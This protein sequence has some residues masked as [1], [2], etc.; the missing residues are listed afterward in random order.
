MKP[1]PVIL[2]V[3][4]IVGLGI[5][6]AMAASPAKK[7]AEPDAIDA[8]G[9]DAE[10]ALRAIATGNSETCKNTGLV[11][12]NASPVIAAGLVRVSQFLNDIGSLP[13]DVSTLVRSSV[14]TTEPDQMAGIAAILQTRQYDALARDLY[15]ISGYVK[16]LRQGAPSNVDP[17]S[18]VP[19]LPGKTATP[20][21]QTPAVK[22]SNELSESQINEIAAVVKS[23]DVARIRA[24]ADK[25]RATNPDV[26]LALDG[27][28]MQIEAAKAKGESVV[29][30]PS[31]PTAPSAPSIPPTNTKKLL[32]G[33]VAIAFQTAKRPKNAQ[34][35]LGPTQPSSAVDLARQ[36]QEQ[37][38][39][40][41]KD[42][43][44][45]SETALSLAKTYG[46]APPP[47][48]YWGK[49][50][51]SYTDFVNDKKRYNAELEKLAASDLARKDE[52]LAARVKV[53]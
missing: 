19:V 50:N 31:V 14:M 49:K 34:G 28:V 9:N 12:A 38:N 11:V 45:G 1:L 32:A 13:V 42:G 15:A 46:I 52:W 51:G 4:G 41:R 5:G 16:W 44:Y 39:L 35:Q 8:P 33:K 18:L 20:T 22:P 3:I 25:Y 43:S 17:A 2:G 53:Q 30:S 26:S 37:E 21:S 24:L 29:V 23:G 36:F 6:V 27:V 40:S 47:P 48:L 7:T 10:K